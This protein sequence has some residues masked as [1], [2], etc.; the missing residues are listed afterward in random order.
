MLLAKKNARTNDVI[1]YP[2]TGKP[3]FKENNSQ[4]NRK[5]IPEEENRWC[6]VCI[7]FFNQ[8]IFL[9]FSCAK[10]IARNLKRFLLPK[11]FCSTDPPRTHIQPA[12]KKCVCIN[13]PLLRTSRSLLCNVQSSSKC[14]RS[15]YNQSK[16]SSLHTFS[17]EVAFYIIHTR[18]V[19]NITQH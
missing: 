16:I 2:P 9:Y 1:K 10:L 6:D 18:S 14:Q 11:I 15:T 8:V 4:F 19:K 5:I 7:T 12:Q 13:F 3:S 17:L